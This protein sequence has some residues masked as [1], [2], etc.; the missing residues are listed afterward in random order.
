MMFKKIATAT[1]SLIAISAFS[2]AN[3]ETS[4]S[5]SLEVAV[6][7]PPVGFD[8][9]VAFN[10]NSANGINR[11]VTLKGG[12][13][14]KL[15]DQLICSDVPYTITATQFFSPSFNLGSGAIGT[16]VLKAGDIIL[17]QANNSISVVF[18][19]DFNCK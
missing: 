10:I 4:H 9:S 14:P 2:S 15:L 3:A 17:G 12:S 18:P 1:L 7:S 16:C 5:C 19:N 8:Q 6:S 13:S 11:S